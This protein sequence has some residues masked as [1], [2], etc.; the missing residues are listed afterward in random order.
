M[1][2]IISWCGKLPTGLLYQLLHAAESRG[3]DSTGVAYWDA[4]LGQNMLVKHAVTAASFTKVNSKYVDTAQRSI[5]GI[6]HTRN[7]SPKMP[8]DNDN[9]HPFL[10]E[11]WVFAHNGVVRNWRTLKTHYLEQFVTEAI[12]DPGLESRVDYL[13]GP[14]IESMDFTSVHGALGLVWLHGQKAYA[15]R[16]KKELTAARVEWNYASSTEIHET[17]L[18]ASTWGIIEKALAAIKN[19]KYDADEIITADHATWEDAH[20]ARKAR[21]DPPCRG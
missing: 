21:P 18:V 3:R 19:V 10:Y 15:F 16:S 9:A 6:A 14:A 17:V 2:A 4:E 1:C 20:R 8:I 13:K 5:S 7:A 11:T 12:N